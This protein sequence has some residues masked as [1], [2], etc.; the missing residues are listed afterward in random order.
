MSGGISR[1]EI[2]ERLGE[3]GM[4]VVYR[5]R[6]TFLKR[7]VALKRIKPG[8][9][10]DPEVRARFL[11]ECRAAAAINHPNVA[12][13]YEAGECD[14]GSIY[15][16]SEL[17]RGESLVRHLRRGRL[18]FEE[19]LDLAVQL[20]QG[21]AAAHEAGI[22]HRDIKPGNVM[23]T[24]DR[25][26]KIL[27]FGLARLNQPL[28]HQ[29]DG[30]GDT[31]TRTRPGHFL[32]T[33]AYMSPEQVT[34]AEVDATSDVFSCG[35]VLYEM[36]S[37]R[38]PFSG[39]SVSE[40]VRR[41]LSEDPPDLDRIAED[42]PEGFVE[43]IGK[44]LAKNPNDR[45]ANASEMAKALTAIRHQTAP[46]AIHEQ[47][48]RP[49]RG[50]RVGIGL[51]A[52]TAI[53]A[54]VLLSWFFGRSTLAFEKKDQL[55]ITSVVNL[56]DEEAFDLALRTA[57]EADLQQ[58]PYVSVF[59]QSQVTSVLQLMRLDPAAPVNES[60]GRDIC[61][62]AGIRA[63]LVPRILAVGE[64]YELQ[65]ILVDPTSGRHVDRIR[66]TAQGREQVLLTAIDKLTREVR[67]RLG[68]SLESIDE[69]DIPVVTVATS[70]W[71]ALKYL[72]MARSAWWVGHF[73]EASGL[74]E[75]ALEKDPQFASA[76]RMLAL[77]LIQFK[78]EKERGKQ[79]LRE[80]LLDAE[81]LPEREYM[82]IRAV[83][84]QFV[85]E[86]LE[87]ALAEYELIRELYPDSAPAFN[88]SGHILLALGRTREA[89][90]MFERAAE[91]DLTVT[92]PLI[93]LYFVHLDDFRDAAKATE[94]ARRLVERAPQNVSFGVMLAW[95]L[96]AEGRLDEA[97]ELARAAVEEEPHHP[98]GLPNLAHLLYA[99]GADDEAVTHYRT[100]HEL[101]VNGELRGERW[102]AARDLAIALA[103]VGE[104][105]EARRIA[106]SEASIILE[107]SKGAEPDVQRQLALSQL[108]A[109]VGLDAQARE[110]MVRAQHLGPKGPI[111]ILAL[112]QTYA[113][114]GDFETALT[115]VAHALDQ[116]YP[117]PFMPLYLPSLRPLRSDSRFLA[118]FTPPDEAIDIEADRDHAT[119]ELLGEESDQETGGSVDEWWKKK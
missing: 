26:I 114:L 14:G 89:L 98:Y 105:D 51:A 37:G 69:A 56:T 62:F 45:F 112:A 78:G 76:K 29:A 71:E 39:D 109:I 68:E 46:A 87:A 66:V 61:R 32:G 35:C 85:D 23:V 64:V 41:I 82:M 107:D 50:R 58:S 10:E 93:S 31:L 104:S 113:L 60:L 36:T 65:A 94:A 17:I 33:P 74:F 15:L 103:A 9:A 96:A 70:S 101:T 30:D 49:T 111:S 43:I 91:L 12:T 92:P 28:E 117:D 116:G 77:V 79:L 16:A 119:G 54:A 102:A 42:A 21:L 55:L 5:A 100:V 25:R 73:D 27:D 75:L 48:T 6:D 13:I 3:G 34:G 22:V 72:A 99:S 47:P 20:T 90:P 118:L 88:N 115:G 83:N 7:D 4:G 95:S 19:Q 38:A 24:D 97:L 108:R 18:S 57:L 110:H 11:R 59:Q 1:F 2:S 67:K 86:D 106:E 40:T 80:A 63:M 52:A 81:G 44:A 84:K 53:V 8:L